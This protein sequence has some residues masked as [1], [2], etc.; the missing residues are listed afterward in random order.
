MAAW[1]QTSD[2]DPLFHV[3]GRP[4]RVTE[5]LVAAYV[6]AW[7]ALAL[8]SAFNVGGLVVSL[9]ALSTNEVLGHGWVWQLVTYPFINELNSYFLFI[10]LF[11]FL[12]GRIVERSIGRTAFLGLYL[13]VTLVPALLLCAVSALFHRPFP[14]AGAMGVDLSFFIAFALI[15]PEAPVFL[16]NIPVKWFAWGTVGVATLIGVA[17][18]DWI[19][20]LMLWSALTVTYLAIRLPFLG[21]WLNALREKQERT[22]VD[23]ERARAERERAKAAAVL[24]QKKAEENRRHQSIDPILEKI[25]KTG[26]QSL[27]RDERLVLEEARKEL[28]RRDGAKK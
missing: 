1:M 16:F 5:T 22:K 10:A 4:F 25:S 13:G 26:M 15:F 18:H 14:Y 27:T 23:R 7:V 11:I 19:A 28:L 24:E 6:G 12:F 8:A 21:E 20:L 17:S 3:G 9:F 2:D